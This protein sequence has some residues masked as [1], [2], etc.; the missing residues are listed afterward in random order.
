[1]K[2]DGGVLYLMTG[3]HAVV[4]ATNRTLS[5]DLLRDF[6]FVAI[7]T[8]F[9]FVFTVAPDSRII[10]EQHAQKILPITDRALILERPHR[11][12]ERG[13]ALLADPAPLER[14]LGVTAT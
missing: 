12:S 2:P 14:F 6:D 7:V 9:P 11:P 8:R 10:V 4:S 1:M 3:G 5:Y 13:A